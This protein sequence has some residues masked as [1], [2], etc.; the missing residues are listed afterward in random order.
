MGLLI[1]LSVLDPAIPTVGLKVPTEDNLA[2]PAD[3]A[4]IRP[5]RHK[6]DVWPCIRVAD[7]GDIRPSE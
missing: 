1:A 6:P 4:L 2:L 7:C 5:L 3:K